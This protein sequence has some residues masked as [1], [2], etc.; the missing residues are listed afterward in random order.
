MGTGCGGADA[1]G[2]ATQATERPAPKQRAT[3]QPVPASLGDV[4][5]SA[6]DIVDFARQEER[7]KVVAA[8][9]ELRRAAEGSAA[10]A[11]TKGG[12][13]PSRIAELQQ[14]AR[15]V[16]TLAPRAALLRV[17]LAANQVSG[18]MPELYARYS[19][20]V[21][22]AV[23]KLDYL[24][25]EAQL[26]SLAGDRAAVTAAASALSS[27]W[28]GLRPAV[29]DAGGDA[30][31]TRYARHVSAMGRLARDSGER[32]LQREAVHGLALVDELEQAF[33]RG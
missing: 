14:R 8:A 12:A 2:T 30:V 9:R 18:L 1:G 26:R 16:E 13:A 10:A 17:A 22:P 32:A 15:L 19:D 5:S 3:K 31:A 7:A 27:T 25:R 20:R 33:R 11:L 21:P 28:R 24:D 4:E 6:E 29:L 23:L